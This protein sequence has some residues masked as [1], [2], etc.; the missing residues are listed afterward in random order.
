M[1]RGEVMNHL[2]A[3]YKFQLIPVANSNDYTVRRI[4]KVGNCPHF[5]NF[6]DYNKP[7]R[8]KKIWTNGII[9]E[10]MAYPVSYGHGSE[11]RRLLLFHTASFLHPYG[12]IDIENSNDCHLFRISPEDVIEVF[13]SKNNANQAGVLLTLLM[14][15][16][17]KEEINQLLLRC[18]GLDDG[19]N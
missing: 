19:V 16:S 8:H 18:G 11:D 12:N 10:Y 9:D 1:E 2:T 6:F 15:G 5:N 13:I 3:Y 14:D 7:V 17:L 4:C